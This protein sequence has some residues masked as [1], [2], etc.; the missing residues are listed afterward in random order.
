VVTVR[1]SRNTSKQRAA[2][3]QTAIPAPF[4]QV[5]G[6]DDDGAMSIYLAQPGAQTVKKATSD[7]HYGY[8]PAVAEMPSSFVYLW[9]KG[10]SA[11][12]AYVREIE[13]TLLDGHGNTVRGGTRLTDHSG[14]T[15]STYDYDPAVAVAPN[16]HIGVVWYR[17]LDNSSD[18]TSNENI[19]Y[20]ILD[21]A[22]NIVVPP[23]NL[24]NNPFWGSG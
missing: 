19:Y 16:G 5:F 7:W 2:T 21:A 20:A 11:A 13:Y 6:D 9:T 10:R 14:A 17:H 24:T 8:Y 1:S 4:A 15:M 3:F 23:T 22:G 18:Y 12:S